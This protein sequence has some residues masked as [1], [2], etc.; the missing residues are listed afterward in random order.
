MWALLALFPAFPALAD[1][2]ACA[3]TARRFAVD[4]HFNGVLL[5]GQGSQNDY[6]VEKTAGQSLGDDHSVIV[7]NNTSFD[8]KLDELAT[9][10]ME[11]CYL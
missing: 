10:L 4:Q 9:A 11:A 3:V 6:V 7:L 2:A 1:C 5:V 8:Q